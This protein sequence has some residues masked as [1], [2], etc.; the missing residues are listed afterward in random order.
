MNILPCFAI[1]LLALARLPAS[2]NLA[3]FAC[4]PEWA[5]LAQELGGGSVV[6]N[7]ATTGLQDPHHIQARP[8]LIALIRD[9]D[10]IACTG[11]DR[12]AGWLPLLLQRASNANIQVSRPSHFIATQYVKMLGIPQH[13]DRSHRDV[14]AAENPHIQTSPANIFP[15]AKAMSQRFVQLDPSN[16]VV[17]EERM[18]DFEQRWRAALAH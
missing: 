3:I 8:S 6:A 12:E 7:S 4:E 11:A 2:A 15:V 5:A 14:H 9:A 18:G 13:I 10:M 1:A 16:L 17:Y